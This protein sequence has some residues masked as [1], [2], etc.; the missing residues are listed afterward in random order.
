MANIVIMPKQGLQMTEG[1]ITKWLKAVGDTVAEG[2]PL[3][4]ME[5]DKLTITID[6]SFSGTLLKIVR[7]EGEEVPIT[8]PIAVIGDAGEDIS[9]LDLGV[10]VKTEDAPAPETEAPA[11]IAAP[12]APVAPVAP[13]VTA[14]VPAALPKAPGERVFITPRARMRCAE[15]GI[16]DYTKI[17]GTGDN[18]LI[19]ERDVL[20]YK[21][22]APA[23]ADCSRITIR[24]NMA[25]VEDYLKAAAEGGLALTSADLVAKAAVAAAKK[26]E[27]FAD[28]PVKALKGSDVEEYFPSLPAETNALLSAGGIY[29]DGSCRKTVLSIAFCEEH[30]EADEAAAFLS[31]VKVLLE[32]PLL[33]LAI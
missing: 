22:P 23:A 31:R 8:E 21:I 11:P 2:E 20:A 19:V 24:V 3:F 14:P 33:M 1:L 7:E 28:L 18:G 27:A 13:A 10:A 5:T 9:Q 4:E 25:A 26:Y 30:V 29:T 32:N 15:R 17:P 6:S 16:A 12:A